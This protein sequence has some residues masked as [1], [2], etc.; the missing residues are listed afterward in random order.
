MHRPS[1]VAKGI[2]K[3]GLSIDLGASIEVTWFEDDLEVLARAVA[4]RGRAVGRR[5]GSPA[6]ML[7]SIGVYGMVS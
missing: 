3:Q 2:V 4:H 6:L 7:C 5:R 1:N